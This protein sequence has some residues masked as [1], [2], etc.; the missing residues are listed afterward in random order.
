MLVGNTGVASFKS[1]DPLP[2]IVALQLRKLKIRFGVVRQNHFCTGRAHRNFGGS[3]SGLTQTSA[4]KRRLNT[5][6][7]ATRVSSDRSILR[8]NQDLYDAGSLP[9][10]WFKCCKSSF[11]LLF[12]FKS[13]ILIVPHWTPR[14]RGPKL[15][16]QAALA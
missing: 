1:A 16:P 9:E 13:N 12:G 7:V 15:Q 11:A 14:R 5:D 10:V 3:T 6:E 2:C 8:V 4:A